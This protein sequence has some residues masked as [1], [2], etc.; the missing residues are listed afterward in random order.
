MVSLRDKL[1]VSSNIGEGRQKRLY[2]K[3]GVTEN[4]FPPSHKTAGNPRQP[5]EADEFIDDHIVRFMD[6]GQSQVL[7]VTGTQGLGKTN[8]LEHYGRLLPTVLQERG[9]FYVVRYYTDPEDNFGAVVR[10]IF[11]EL[12]VEHLKRMAQAAN[13]L[14]PEERAAKL[15][16]VN[17]RE[18]RFAFKELFRYESNESKMLEFSKLLL[19]YL[20]G[21][22][23]YK[24]HEELGL[25][26]RLES[27]EMKTQALRDVIY[28]SY[29][30]K[31]LDGLFLFLDELEKIGLYS[32]QVVTTFLSAIRA[33]ID[34]LPQH[35]FLALAMTPDARDRYTR[36][37]PALQGR[38]QQTAE[39]HPLKTETEAL[40]LYDFY[41]EENRK[42]AFKSSVAESWQQ[43]EHPPLSN[44][45]VKTLFEALLQEGARV[46]V[47]GVIQRRFLDRLHRDTEMVFSDVN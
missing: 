35:L 27:T 38:L 19:D 14:T 30:I 15:D 17:S 43:G 32:K 10:R 36:E 18:L 20:M 25:Q 47:D 41:L 21:L 34:A 23:V 40:A 28:L 1:G 9:N 39:L 7:V 24:R 6:D 12:G 8:L 22:R 42:R 2:E 26:H 11:Q 45:R 31:A 4:P 13:K 3:Y 16:M 44:T 33:L 46:G 5:L 29:E 37:F